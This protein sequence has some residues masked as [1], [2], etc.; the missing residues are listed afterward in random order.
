[1]E[2]PLLHVQLVLVFL[3]ISHYGAGGSDGSHASGGS[4]V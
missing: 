1:M 3:L 2:N 4:E